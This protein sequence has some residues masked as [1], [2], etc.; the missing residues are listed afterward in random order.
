MP[1]RPGELISIIVQVICG[2]AMGSILM[3]ILKNAINPLIIFAIIIVTIIAILDFADYLPAFSIAFFAGYVVEF[4][5]PLAQIF[6]GYEIPT[7]VL[8][9]VGIGAVVAVK[10]RHPKGRDTL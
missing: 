5:Y 10:L 7:L 6:D 1:A 4:F 8:S 9:L 3:D 2:V